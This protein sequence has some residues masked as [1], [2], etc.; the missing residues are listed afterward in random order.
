M[1]L[2]K[3][4]RRTV[5]RSPPFNGRAEVQTLSLMDPE[6]FK[7]A[8]FGPFPSN[9]DSLLFSLKLQLLRRVLEGIAMFVVVD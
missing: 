3:F 6:K 9:S 2:C 5:P 7:K 4:W 1:T 8:L